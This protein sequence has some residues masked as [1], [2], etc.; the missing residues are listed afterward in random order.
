NNVEVK[1]LNLK[2]GANLSA[3]NTY[4]VYAAGSSITTTGGGADNDTVTISNNLIT[5]AYNGIYA[6]GI[7]GSGLSMIK[8][9]I[10][11]NTIGSTIPAD[12]ITFRGIVLWYADGAQVSGNEVFNII[13]S[14]SV[15][16]RGIQC[17][18]GVVNSAISENRV[19]DIINTTTS[20]FRAGQGI[21]VASGTGTTANVNVVNNAV[22]NLN[23]HGSGTSTNNSWGII[24]FTGNAYNIWHNSVALSGAGTSTG[25]VDLSGCILL[26]SAAS[27]ALDVRNNAFYNSRVPGNATSG[28]SYGIY[29]V[30][31]AAGFTFI[32]YNDYYVSG[33]RGML[34]Y[35]GGNQSTLGLWQGA[36]L[37]DINSKDLDPLFNSTSVLIPQVGSP[38]VGAGW[39]VGVATD[40]LGV[41]RNPS[42]TIGA[43]ENAADAMG[44]VI[45]YTPL[46]NT[47][48]TTARGLGAVI[49]DASGVPTSGGGLPVLYWRINAG[50]WSSTTGSW[51]I[52]DSFAFTPFGTPV[53][54]GS[55]VSYYVAAQDGNG[56]PNVSVQPSAGA[57]GLLPNPPRATVP[58]TTPSSYTVTDTALNGDYTVGLTLFNE[59]TGLNL[60]L[61][62]MT[63][64][65]MR[66]VPVEEGDAQA[67]QSAARKTGVEESTSPVN[68]PD[69]P[70]TVLTEV[71]EEYMGL[72]REGKPY[73]GVLYVKQAEHP[74]LVFPEGVM[75]VYAT[76][77]AAVADLNLRGVGGAVRLLLVDGTYPTETFPITV[78][79]QAENMPS[80]T[81]TVTIKPNTSV[82]A[83]VAGASAS[84]PVFKVLSSWVTIDGSNTVGGTTRDLT[85][86]NTSATSPTVVVFGSTGTTP[87]GGVALKNTIAI[88]GST[89]SSA[90]VVSDGG[91]VGNPGYFSGVTIQNNFIQKAYIGVYATGGT[92][93]QQGSLLTLADNRLDSTGTGAI[94]KTGLYMQGVAGA[95][96]TGN[97]I[98]NFSG[99][100]GEDDR[101]IWLATGTIDAVVEGNRIHSLNY[102]GTGGYSGQGIAVT[103]GQAVANVV[104]R[105]NML[106]NLSG[107]GWNYTSIPGDNPYGIYVSGTQAEI[108][109]HNNS[110]HLYGNTLNKA[111][112]LSMGIGVLTGSVVDVRNNV[113][114]NN[115]GL[116][117]TTG[118]GS[119]AIWLQTDNTQLA[120]ADNNLYFV[121]PTGSGVKPVG[122]IAA[123][124][125]NTLADWQT[126]T[127]A[128]GASDYGDPLYLTP[129]NLHINT[130]VGLASP[131]ANMGTNSAGVLFDIDGETRAGTPDA[132]ADEFILRAPLA[133]TLFAPVNGSPL[134]LPAG[135]LKW[136]SAAGATGYDVYYDANPVPVTQV[137]GN[138]PDTTWGYTG[139]AGTYFWD[140]VSRNAD[141]TTVS[142]NGPFSFTVPAPDIGIA[143]FAGS[144]PESWSGAKHAAVKGKGNGPAMT[145]AVT[146]PALKVTAHPKADFTLANTPTFE[147][148]VYENAGIPVTSYQVG[149]LLDGTPQAPV[150]N[151]DPLTAGDDDTLTITWPGATAGPHTFQ[152]YTILAGDSDPLNDSSAV[153]AFEVY[154]PDVVFHQGFNNYSFPPAG[155]TVI[156]ADTSSGSPPSWFRDYDW[157]QPEGTAYAAQVYYGS[158]ALGQWDDWLITPNTGGLA[159]A[160]TVDSLTFWVR[161]S[162]ASG[163]FPDS[164]Q[165]LVSTLTSDTAD[166]DTQLDYIR[167]PGTAWTRFAY[168]LPDGPNRYVAFRTFLT[169]A[170][171]SGLYYGLDDVRITRYAFTG[172]FAAD[173]PSLNFGTVL[174]GNSVDDTVWVTNTGNLPLNIATVTG[175]TADFGINPTAA[176][177]AVGDSAPFV[178]TFAPLTPVPLSATF[179]FNHDGFSTPDTV[180]ALGVGETP[181][182]AFLADPTSLA[183]GS[184]IIGDSLSLTVKVY[185]QGN[186]NLNLTDISTDNTLFTAEPSTGTVPP[187]DSLVVTVKFK[188]LT[189]VAQ[190]GNL[191]FTHNAASSPDTVTL[192]GTGESGIP[193]LFLSVT[194][195]EIFDENPI[196]PGKSLKPAKRA[197]FGKPI[198]P[199][200]YPNWSNLLSEITA[201]GAFAPATSESDSAGGMVIGVSHMYLADPLKN[202]WK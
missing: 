74:E 51:V 4:G 107:D 198:E 61:Q 158:N 47:S 28:Y 68:A 200:N 112:A 38:L 195:V 106:W 159:D 134:E 45:T 89:S 98:G 65:V 127:G 53:S 23:G 133:A 59:I 172:G 131:A 62:K 185:N 50:T 166:F 99:T 40:I 111:G 181:A 42:P 190:A 155:W 137:S 119:T 58:P 115:L 13:S 191:V 199:E 184:V 22:W 90:V 129:T 30:T 36:T 164:L 173:P 171:T 77:T 60:T 136:N 125:S 160:Y 151:T 83:T 114:V 6:S 186:I 67:E 168:A 15:V 117:S 46:P 79:I 169:D 130:A 124:A 20:G 92:A 157:A 176:M 101:G 7:T 82:V 143:E 179:V 44:P 192:T 57:S 188:P 8:T 128:E 43:Y 3:A 104:V 103:S 165:I 86:Q 182:A 147:V 148:V 140:I 21:S 10:S 146:S 26:N 193:Q 1:N 64:K 80:S 189:V 161:H 48:N 150:S 108:H 96:V 97:V 177:I 201:Q 19:H 163:T 91:T 11:G 16:L 142:A 174:I 93:P 35:L 100:D 196:K 71:E 187:G 70:K 81:N 156:N 197:K 54:A 113:V 12:Y 76:I 118:Y 139:A 49:T 138:Q 85:I 178:V 152:A 116:L 41:G 24:V 84:G 34:G 31:P 5:R 154:G 95:A 153:L 149:W 87:I 102:T 18:T 69:A 105:N 94:R 63:R 175:A 109:L 120:Q 55:V 145:E 88:N 135:D 167:V 33:A 37:Q 202:K 25:S 170:F 9:V 194:P 17:E 56:T 110:I 183:F 73:E 144:R 78:S 32:D 52:A 75:G 121:N 162:G 27:T 180:E 141:S 14:E 132:G 2:A 126:A 39:N 123:T 72:A 29:S 66:Q 122:Q